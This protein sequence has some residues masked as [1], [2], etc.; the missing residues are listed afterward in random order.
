MKTLYIFCLHCRVWLDNKTNKDKRSKFCSRSCAAK[1]NN[2]LF[3]KRIADAKPL[4]LTQEEKN[5]NLFYLE[6]FASQN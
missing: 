6:N 4:K 3:P 5:Y 1:V 2:K